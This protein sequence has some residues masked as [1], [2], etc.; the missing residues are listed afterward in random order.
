MPSSRLALAAVG[1]AGLACVGAVLI[2]IALVRVPQ[3]NDIARA[4]TTTFYWSDGTT[5]LGRIGAANRTSVGLDQ[6]PLGVQRAVLAAED[7]GF[8]DHSGFSPVGIARALWQNVNGSETQGGSTITQQYAKNAFLTQDQTF[9][10]KLRELILSVKLE[11]TSSKD[12]ILADY[13]NTVYYGRGAYGIE[14]A[15]QAYFGV[16]ASALTVEQ[17]A[18]LAALLQS[19]NALAPEHNPQALRARWAYTLDGMVAEGWLDSGVRAAM[20]FPDIAD[21]QPPTDFTKGADGYLFAAAQQQL[22][23]MGYSADD[24][25]VAGLNVVT[26]FDRQAQA[27][28]VAAVDTAP[29]AYRSAGVR[30]GLASVDPRSGAVPALYGGADYQL[31]RSSAATEL[32]G[33]A[34]SSFLPFGL[35][36]GLNQGLSL[37]SEFSGASPV[38]VAGSTVANAGDES[39]SKVTLLYATVNSIQ[40][41]FV[42]MNDLIGPSATRD[43]LVSAGIPASTPGLTDQVTNVVGEAAPT[44]LESAGAYATLAARGERVRPSVIAQVRDQSGDLTYQLS[45]QPERAFDANV[46][47]RVTASL[48]RVVT[49]G[50]GSAANV[51]DRPLAGKT[52]VSEGLLSEWF[53]GYAPQLAA[54]VMVIRRDSAGN[55][56]TLAGVG[57]ANE[58]NGADVPARIFGEFMSGALEGQPV[59][60]FD[61]L[62]IK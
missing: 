11:L 25:N 18:V 10:R 49:Y 28:A 46:A 30:I 40:T 35:A 4:Q 53:A 52:G 43:A 39:Y 29:L 12:Q 13:L 2:A 56:I 62:G 24:L 50:N 48:R 44:V 57:G 36:A 22:L 5:V 14:A 33:L 23:T 15:A 3:P 7:R 32:R 54:A 42:Q 58:I 6:V 16:P 9:S 21:Y 31:S 17:G 38:S 26:T 51:G 37:D 41:P 20:R 60:A 47:D 27:A 45:A 34:G 59:E 19:P 1:L 8:Y 61:D 55:A